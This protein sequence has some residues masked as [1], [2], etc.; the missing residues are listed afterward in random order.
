MQ[1]SAL[2]VGPIAI[3]TVR[4]LSR[5]QPN[6]LCHEVAAHDY[7]QIPSILAAIRE[8]DL[9]FILTAFDDENCVPLTLT[10]GNELQTIDVLTLAVLSNQGDAA[11]PVLD[12]LTAV[13]DTVFTVPDDTHIGESMS[14][15]VMV[16]ADLLHQESLIGIDFVDVAAIMRGIGAGRIGVGV[17][18]GPD[19]GKV[20]ANLALEHLVA[21]NVVISDVRSVLAVIQSSAT[22]TLGDF[23]VISEVIHAQALRANILIGMT[24][25]TGLGDSIKVNILTV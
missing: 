6:I 19:R 21:Q 24:S 13:V 8:S 7:E 2:G 10:I 22:D 1:I 18:S 12:D 3:E 14:Q 16:I 15:I 20:G 11:P 17:A 23:D 25:K 5:N 4:L 9:L